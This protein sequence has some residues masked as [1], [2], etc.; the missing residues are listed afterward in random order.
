M[1]IVHPRCGGI[2]VHKESVVACVRRQGPRRA[3][4]EIRRFG[5]T[6]SELLALHAWIVETGC[7]HL[8]SC[9]TSRDGQGV[10]DG[11][12]RP[13]VAQRPQD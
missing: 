3:Q 4:S 8:S 7:T 12:R 13:T 1:E 2:D 11:S 5:T 10:D 6:T 9:R